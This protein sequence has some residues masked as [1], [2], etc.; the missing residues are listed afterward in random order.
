MS[1]VGVREHGANAG[2][3]VE[4]YIRF[5]GSPPGSAWCSCFVSW[6]FR[7]AAILTARFGRARSWS[8]ARHD[9]WR[10][11][12]QLPGRPPPQQA[13]V[14][15]YTW[16]H[17]DICHVGFLDVWGTGPACQTVEGN[18]S[19]GKQSRD[20]DGVYVNWRLKRMVAAVANVV[21]DPTYTH[22]E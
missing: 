5:V 7:Q 17:P 12:R 9:V 16:G 20:G 22:R 18:T 14:V 6:C 11:G 21:D 4:K 3:D 10:A 1:Q 2:P 15:M 13:D 8:D 19:G